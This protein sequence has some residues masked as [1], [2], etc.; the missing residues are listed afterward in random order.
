MDC[1]PLGSSVYGILKTRILNGLPLPFP[2]DLP[3]PGIELKS[4][5]SQANSLLSDGIA[6]LFFTN[7]TSYAN[8]LVASFFFTFPPNYPAL[9]RLMELY[10]LLRDK[11]GNSG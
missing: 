8:I 2:G 10:E 4:P 7:S 6:G 5:A 11:R 3:D 9:H 1:S